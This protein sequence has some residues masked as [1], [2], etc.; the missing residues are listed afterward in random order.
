MGPGCLSSD[1]GEGPHAGSALAETEVVTFGF[2]Q[3]GGAQ[4]RGDLGGPRAGAQRGTQVEGVIAKEA[5]AQMA[6]GREP[7]AITTFAVVVGERADHA[8]RTRGAGER[9]VTRGSVAGGTGHG[10]QLVNRGEAGEDLVGRNVRVALQLEI[11]VN[12]HDFD[13]AHEDGAIAG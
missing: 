11:F 4:E 9:E 5:Q 3:H 6:V 13:E 7:Y 2:D 10:T 8:Y 12:R 1:F